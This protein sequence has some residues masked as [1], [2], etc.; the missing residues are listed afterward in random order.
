MYEPLTE[1]NQESMVFWQQ[2]KESFKKNRKACKGLGSTLTK[3]TNGSSNW[4][5]EN[6][7]FNLETWKAL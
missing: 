2:S 5:T 3:A 4:K 1:E 6:L 7:Q